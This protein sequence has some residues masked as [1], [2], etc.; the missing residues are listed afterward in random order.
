MEGVGDDSGTGA[1][2]HLSGSLGR[3]RV[4]RGEEEEK[5]KEK[6][7]GGK[8]IILSVLSHMHD[9]YACIFSILHVLI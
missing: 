9:T 6:K 5:K 7:R 8:S 3:G 4:K 2:N 1:S